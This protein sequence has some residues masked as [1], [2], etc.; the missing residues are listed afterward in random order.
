[1]PVKPALNADCPD[2]TLKA[3]QEADFQQWL[4]AVDR[5]LR[6]ECQVTHLDL[7]KADW[8]GFFEDDFTPQS[9]VDVSIEDYDG[10][11]FLI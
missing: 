8:R 2:L 11:L 9:A 6:H 4:K 3:L 5:L 10:P 1:M 7:P